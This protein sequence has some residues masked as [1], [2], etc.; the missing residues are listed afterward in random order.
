MAYFRFAAHEIKTI[1]NLPFSASDYSKFK[2]GDADVAA[3]F[4]KTLAQYFVAAHKETLLAHSEIVVLPSPYNS[5]PTASS[6]MCDYFR[7]GINLF[8]FQHGRN[9]VM[10]SKIHRY[11]T[12]STDYGNLDFEARK[13]LIESD[14][15]H[16]DKGFLKQRLCLFLDDIKI[17]GSHEYVIKKQIEANV[18]ENNGTFGFVYFAELQNEN[19]APQ[20][21]NYLNYAHVK[22]LDHIAEIMEKPS[23]QFNTRVIKYILISGDI[24]TFLEKISPSNKEKLFNWAISN[25]YHLMEEYQKNIKL[26]ITQ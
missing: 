19:I 21:E 20:F 10:E 16:L 12:Y 23:F 18:L 8:L 14:K 17:T 6:L 25:N 26:G 5:I 11:K 15:Y 13:T 1:E 4:G 3:F 9:A 22:N 7:Q 24:T 2:F